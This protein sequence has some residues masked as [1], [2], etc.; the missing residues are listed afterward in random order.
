MAAVTV[1]ARD[2]EGAARDSGEVVVRDLAR[3][4]D[5]LPEFE[6]APW[7]H[8]DSDPEY[9]RVVVETMPGA[10]GPYLMRVARDANALV[11][12][13]LERAAMGGNLG[14]LR[15]EHPVVRCLT[16][17]HGGV[18][19]ADDEASARRVVE[20]LGRALGSEAD[21]VRFLGL[22]I[23]SPLHAAVTG[24]G[25]WA[26]R[27]RVVR[28]QPH[29]R[30]RVPATMD[31]FL[32]ARSRN[33]RQNVRRY[34]RRLEREFAGRLELR[35]FGAGAETDVERLFTDLEAVASKTYQRGLGVGF[36]GDALQRR[37]IELELGRGRYLAWFLDLDGKPVAFWDG[38]IHRGVFFIGSPGYD[39]ALAHVH[40]GTW[41]QMRMTADLC[42][43]DDVEAL[44]YGMGDAQYKRSFGDECW[45]D[46]I[47]HLFAPRPRA[48]AANAVR[49]ATSGTSVLARRLA[50][51]WDLEQRVR[52][53]WRRR[54]QS[55]R[56]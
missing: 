43:R 49:I 56:R 7:P 36:R 19:G 16:V 2:R 11:V 17:V 1:P 23:G 33:T 54:A 24:Y 4:G 15:I 6:H 18:L 42:E 41:L 28:P 50:A 38:S 5:L 45:E 46:A 39:P 26:C 12:G 44:D 20:A 14:Y 25:S 34:G 13:R 35:R 53:L 37:T 51:R 31:E 47:V 29:W 32:A 40:P 27:D 9:F 21:V 48:L 52:R 30:A 8:Q 3:L 10:I 55:A 22:K